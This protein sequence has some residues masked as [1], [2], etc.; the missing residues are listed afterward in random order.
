[1]ESDGLHI[2][3]SVEWWEWFIDGIAQEGYDLSVDKHYHQI[4]AVK[5]SSEI[6]APNIT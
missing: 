5:T 6:A 1:M 4:V 2:G 3:G